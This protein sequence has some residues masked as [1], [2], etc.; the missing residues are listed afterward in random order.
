LI[1][2]VAQTPACGAN[3]IVCENQLTGDADYDVT[4][5]G[6]G[7]PGLQGFA[8]DISVNTGQTVRFKIATESTRYRIDIYRLGFYKG[9]GARKVA[10][11][12]EFTAP[13]IQPDCI[14]EPQSAPQTGVVDCGN[15]S[16]SATWSSAGATSGIYLAKLTRL[17]VTPN[18][19]SH[20]PFIVRDDART[21]EVLFQTSDTT[22]Q[23][24]NQFGGAS[25]YCGGPISTPEPRTAVRGVPPA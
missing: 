15:W 16:V 17:D 21:A 11:L 22:W 12:P 23:A 9:A 18:T 2:G 3:P 1:T 10:T 13:Q 8:A 25:L 6:A 5:G 20:I 7:D 24:Y 19:S 4:G 14:V